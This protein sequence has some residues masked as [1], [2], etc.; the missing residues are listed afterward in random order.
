MLEQAVG[1]P[2]RWVSLNSIRQRA[3]RRRITQVGVA[4]FAVL[5]VILGATFS[6]YAAKGGAPTTGG[7]RSAA[8]PPKYYVAQQYNRGSGFKI[9]VRA[10][11]T[12]KVTSVVRDPK[13]R[14]NCGN[15]LAAGGTHTFFMTCQVWRKQPVA[16]LI[17]RFEVTNS[18]RATTPVLVKGATLG[19]GLYGENLAASPDGAFVAIEVTRP[20]PN[21]ILY[22]NE[23]SAGIYVINTE[24]G[25][26][27]FW[28]TGR[29]VPGK[30][31]FDGAS[32]ISFTQNGSELVLLEKLCHRTRYQR[33]CRS[34]DPTEVRAFGPADHGGSL[35]GGQVL[36]R[37]SAFKK[38]GTSLSDALITPD[39][40]AL[41]S[42]MFN[43][44]KRGLCTLTVARIALTTGKLLNKL[45]QVRTGTRFQGIDMRSFG[46]DPTGRF[47]MLNAADSP[48]SKWVNGWIDHGRLVKLTP[49]DFSG[50]QVW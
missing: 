48:T 35:Q 32:D 23:V 47:L 7:S 6:A 3:I 49:A 45:Y 10:R 27:V 19:G 18:G 8:G 11:T 1:E 20:N 4:S 31:G 38:P 50:E 15:S 40:T 22:T 30:L 33:N 2:P 39:G 25:K 16:V 17:Y 37:L 42:V 41:T 14:A 43:C 29:Y 9:V 26:R 5:A 24:T 46:T 13:P 21:G 12:G 28:R 36:L 34:S 44:P